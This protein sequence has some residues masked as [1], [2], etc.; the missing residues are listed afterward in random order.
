[1]K[2]QISVWTVGLALAAGVACSQESSGFKDSK[3]KIS[4]ALGM[5]LGNNWKRNALE[6]DQV[7]LEIVLQGLRD[8]LTGAPTRMTE[9]EM[10]NTLREFSQFMQQKAEQKRQQEAEANRKAGAAFLEENKKKPGVVTL[11]S[12]LQ[13]RV[14]REGS[15][16]SPKATDTVAVHYRGTLID[17]TEFDSSYKRGQPATFNVSGVIRGWTEALQLMKPG[18]KWELYIP[19]DLAYGDTGRP[20]IP[21]GST[22]IFEVELLSVTTPTPPPV[23]STPV[24][25]DIIKVP[26]AEELAKGA[27]IEV[28]KA[29]DLKRLEEEQRKAAAKAQTNQ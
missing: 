17:G 3:E 24:T 16:D 28:I 5:S 14:L 2:T 4:Y 25:S 22:L 11:P 23:T 26:S 12:G 21:P 9:E 6:P 13:Y 29:E 20:N 1:M 27:K 8:S 10:R 19:A 15:G 7:S 18:A